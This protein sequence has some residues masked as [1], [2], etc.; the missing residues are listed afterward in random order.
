ME[1]S[2]DTY[3]KMIGSQNSS[4]TLYFM[5][6]D[7]LFLATNCSDASTIH[8]SFV[9]DGIIDA[10]IISG[11]VGW[12]I[13][14]DSSLYFTN[15]GFK[16]LHREWVMPNN[17]FKAEGITVSHDGKSVFVYGDNHLYRY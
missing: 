12:A 1:I 4:D 13:K 16:T 11:N 3:D 8:P 7:S 15:D 2:A 6:R 9:N 10:A 17:E 14:S 5:R